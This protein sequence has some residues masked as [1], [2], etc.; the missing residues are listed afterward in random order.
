MTHN[1]VQDSYLT[2]YLQNNNTKLDEG[3]VTALMLPHSFWT[4]TFWELIGK[5]YT[6]SSKWL[7]SL[8]AVETHP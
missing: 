1:V 7:C 6:G 8:E 4:K 5:K 3:S 2:T